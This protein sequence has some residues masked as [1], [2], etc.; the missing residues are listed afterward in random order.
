ML[1]EV[2]KVTEREKVTVMSTI[3]VSMDLRKELLGG[4]APSRVPDDQMRKI[5]QLVDLLDKCLQ[6]DPSKRL[7]VNQAIIHPFVQERM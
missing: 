5:N 7:S 6:L 2:D 4:Q 1:T 3:N